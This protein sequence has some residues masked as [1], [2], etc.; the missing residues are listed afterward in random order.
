MMGTAIRGIQKFTNL[1]EKIAQR[2]GQTCTL[3]PY[4]KLK[5]FQ[6]TVSDIHEIFSEIKKFKEIF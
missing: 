5:N 4:T 6:E 1:G 2:Y 3:V